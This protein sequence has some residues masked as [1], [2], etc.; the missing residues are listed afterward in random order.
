[1]L[2]K[3][4]MN[5]KEVERLKQVM[6]IIGLLVIFSG[7]GVSIFMNTVGRSL[8]LDEAYLVSSLKNRSLFHLT[9]TPLDYIQSAPVI[10][11]Y[12]V[13][14]LMMLF[15]E[16]EAVL[17]LF[18]II[19]Y[20]LAIFLSYY[21]S[22]KVFH[23]KY[24][25][26]CGAFVANIDFLLKYSNVFK[27]YVSEC[28]WVLLVILIYYW[29]QEQKLSWWMMAVLY[30]LLI[31]AANP[32]CFFIGGVLTCEFLGGIFKKEKRIVF[33]SMIS[34]GGICSSFVIYYF[35]WLRSA[36]TDDFMQKY[37]INDRF[38]L[39]P[40]GKDEM[41]TGLKLIRRLFAAGN[42]ELRLLLLALVLAALILG[43]CQ[44]NK[45]CNVML[46]GFLLALFASSLYMFPVRDRL[47]TFSLPLFSVL[48][49]Y[50]IDSMLI[51]D[52]NKKGEIFAVFL[53]AVLIWTNSGIKTFKNADEVYWAGNE[54]NPLIQY[55][56]D[57]VQEDEK[58]Y[59]F[60]NSIPVMTYKNGYGVNRIGNV[61]Q[62]NIIWGTNVLAEADNELV[63][64]QDKCYIL[65]SQADGE[66]IDPLLD[67]LEEQGTL[68]T[69]LDVYDTRLYYYTK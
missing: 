1:M 12:I 69:V 33:H 45:Y 19:S 4:W 61:S 51:T 18:S 13:K 31:W 40:H 37:W 14:L 53:M 23:C 36:A 8:W 65:T 43:V 15:G 42:E 35:Y 39:I 66:T 47:W 57:H 41:E 10:Y 64:S 2:K 52:G 46:I 24:P 48:A 34:G 26:L 62:D 21:V 59:V 28:V 44:K 38:P 3:R 6:D 5:W 30:M 9:S 16:S 56:A 27:P 63:A 67:Y 49:F 54:A 68:E 32:V 20:A 17:R 25:L 55:I 50:F 22:K 7:I 11:L 58:V 60:Y 29:Y